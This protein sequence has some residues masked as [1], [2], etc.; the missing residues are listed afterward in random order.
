VSE[1]ASTADP[2]VLPSNTTKYALMTG[3]QAF[4][5]MLKVTGQDAATSGQMNTFNQNVRV[6]A[7]G[8][9]VD[10]INGPM[11]IANATLASS[12]CDGLIAKESAQAASARKFFANIDFTKGPASLSSA[13]FLM[14]TDAMAKAFYGREQM[15][16][17]AM[18]FNDFRTDFMS[19][20]SA[21]ESSQAA[22]TRK[23]VIGV[24]AA[25]L[26]S[27]DFITF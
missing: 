22:M 9:N 2:E 1:L 8:Q 15:Q 11:L 20:L 16:D 10:L 27:F 5:S 21:T 4:D 6:M 3:R 14:T 24:C 25:M 7:T 17:E 13:Q 19:T 23:M 12:V 26:T 18:A